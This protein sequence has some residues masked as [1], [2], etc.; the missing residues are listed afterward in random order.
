MNAECR[1]QQT[2][3]GNSSIISLAEKPILNSTESRDVRT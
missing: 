3:L 1:T 2:Y